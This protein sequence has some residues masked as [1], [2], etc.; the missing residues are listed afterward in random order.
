MDVQT[1]PVLEGKVAIVTGAAMGMGEA[2]AKLFA[3]A[4]AKVVVADFNDELGEKVAGEIRDAGHEASFVHVDVSNEE[5]V[6]AMVKFAVDTYGRLDVPVARLRPV[7]VRARHGAAGRRRLHQQLTQRDE[8][9][10]GDV[11]CGARVRSGGRSPWLWSFQPVA[12]DQKVGGSNP[13]GRTL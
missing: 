1:Y 6:E 9:R 2:T 7:V 3:E 11:G 12:V 10:S 13:S 5:Q 4:G 8:P